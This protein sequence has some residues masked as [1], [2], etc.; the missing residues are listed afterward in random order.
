M[1]RAEKWCP[2]AGSLEA[3]PRRHCEPSV[4]GVGCGGA[5]KKLYYQ[6]SASCRDDFEA[7][8][9]FRRK[10]MKRLGK[11][12]LVSL[13]FPCLALAQQGGPS[14]NP[15]SDTLRQLLARNSKNLT[16]AAEAMPADKYSYHPTPEQ[17]TYAHLMMHIAQS[18]TVL[19][20]KISGMAAPADAQL[21]ETD[22][23]DKLV[24]ALKDSFTYCTTALTNVDD[25]GLGASV[26]L[27]ATRTSTKAG[28]MITLAYD[29]ADHYSAAAMYLRLNG[30]LPPTAQPAPK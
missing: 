16:A 21:K 23:K 10:H 19:C 26:A 4:P 3:P 25:S 6:K 20:S 28:T 2:E 27:S 13:I 9:R 18:N 7:K 11:V 8:L 22:G 5:L 17:M 1:T 12:V 24:G 15:V 14:S 29:W 30:I